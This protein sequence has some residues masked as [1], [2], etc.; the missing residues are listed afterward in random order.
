M[1]GMILMIS[2]HRNVFIAG[3]ICAALLF[4]ILL[5][6]NFEKFIT[7]DWS[8]FPSYFLKTEFWQYA[9]VGF[10]AQI[11]DGALGMAYGVSATTFLLTFGVSPA[12]ASASVHM[13]EVFT[14]GASGISHMKF[15]NFNRKL[16]NALVIPG[17]IGAAIGAY[18]LYTFDGDAIKPYI[19]AYLL[20]MGIVIIRK[21]I[22]KKKDKR[23]LS[24]YIPPLA[25]FGGFVDAIGGGGW[26]PVVNS[27][28]IG[29]GR[30]PRFSI[31]TASMAEFF[32]AL[33][34]TSVFTLTI[35][36]TNWLVILGLVS[37][38]VFAA[39]VAAYLAGHL[40]P[41]TLMI[42]VGCLIIFLSLRTIFK[43][44]EWV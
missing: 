38:G 1:V 36:I 4:S 11:I 5:Y 26:G 31:G 22:I 17:S 44:L 19:A 8:Q 27:N 39:P 32:V 24:K 40:K 43:T 30:T 10:I 12:T 9:L 37:G 7:F 41:K 14:S 23:F 21:A 34:G 25:L 28:L 33:S 3:A 16:F 13:A 35:G 29:G 15:G 42:V 2:R 6:V 18:I 20:I